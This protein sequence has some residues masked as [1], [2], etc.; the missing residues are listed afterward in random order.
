MRRLRRSCLFVTGADHRALERARSA[1]ADTLI[2]DLED[3]VTPGRKAAARALVSEFLGAGG[4]GSTE[5]TVRVNAIGTTELVE[6]LPS[7]VAAGADALVVPK[8]EDPDALRALDVR[9]VTLERQSGRRVGAVKLLPLLETPTG[10]LR[11]REIAIASA[12]VDALVI[13]HVD[14]SRTLGIRE[15]GAMHG[16]ILHARAHLVL[17]AKAANV[18]A[19]DAVYMRADDDA[20]CEAEARQ[21][22]ALG[23]GGKLLVDARQV[24]LI[25]AVYQPSAAEIDYAH[26]LIAA[27]DAACAEGRGL[28]VFEGR[29]IDLPV[30]EAERSVL[31]RAGA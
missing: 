25:H 26:R 19:I 31:R 22:L 6:D 14:L 9:L 2:L 11:A 23:F 10:V 24:P 7:V 21:G 15:T 8:T 28:F 20:G 5:R 12:R 18:D 1:G 3:T 13:G 29:V 17:A 4:P 27:F 16:T 30:V